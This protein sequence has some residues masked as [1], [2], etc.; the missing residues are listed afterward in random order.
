[1][2]YLQK[3]WYN[4]W[5]LLLNNLGWGD[6]WA[7][8][9]N[10]IGHGVMAVAL[11]GRFMGINFIILTTFAFIKKFQEW[12]VKHKIAVRQDS[13][14]E[15][16]EIKM[17]SEFSLQTLSRQ[18][19]WLWPFQSVI[20]EDLLRHSPDEGVWKPEHHRGW[21]T[22]SGSVHKPEPFQLVAM[23]ASNPVG[24][25]SREDGGEFGEVPRMSVYGTY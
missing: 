7:C 22:K 8:R 5:A 15:L 23:N 21:E 25:G 2:K 1:M 4:V 13:R 16:W 9:G 11:G 17:V 19:P 3:K 24:M 6:G 20:A 10:K 18:C 14:R 12:R